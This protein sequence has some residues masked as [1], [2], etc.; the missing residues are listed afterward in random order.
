MK[1]TVEIVVGWLVTFAGALFACVSLPLTVI[2]YL[3]FT[4]R[5]EI[6]R[7]NLD[8]CFPDARPF[9]RR[10]LLI[11]VFFN[12]FYGLW[13][14][15]IVRLLPVK[16]FTCI[17]KNRTPREVMQE[18]HNGSAC[19]LICP[20]YSCLEMIA[21]ALATNLGNLV[22][23]YRPH[24]NGN[25]ARILNNARSRF[26]QLVNVQ[27]IRLMIKLLRG[28]ARLWFG[29]DQDKGLKGSVFASF[30]NV[31][32]STVSTPA[33]LARISGAPVYFVN[34]R[35][36]F[37]TYQLKLEPFPDS[38]PEDDEVANA[39]TLNRFIERALAND[40]SQYMWFHRRFKTQPGS[41]RYSV[42]S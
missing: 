17:I 20:H 27:D 26:G 40:A 15:I 13:E 4:R 34:F 29:P 21:P 28:S 12:F 1:I 24:E 11:K 23:S 22:M 33:R 3:C 31:P 2:G 41:P 10:V 32:A 18:I 16:T 37:F 8:L 19:L 30:F 25:I 39:E 7:V 35:R 36:Q 9:I 6:A 38:Y 14:I 42:Y 5:R